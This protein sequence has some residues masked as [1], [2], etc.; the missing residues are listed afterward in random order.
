MF[1]RETIFEQANSRWA[2]FE[3]LRRERIDN[4]ERNV[5]VF[6]CSVGSDRMVIVCPRPKLVELWCVLTYDNWRRHAQ[7]DKLFYLPNQSEKRNVLLSTQQHVS[8]G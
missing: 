8:F 7:P 6:T 1:C 4:K 2:A 5:H 3:S